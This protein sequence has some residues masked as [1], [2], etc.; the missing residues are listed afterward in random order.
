MNSNN[1]VHDKHENFCDVNNIDDDRMITDIHGSENAMDCDN[2][3][4]IE[5]NNHEKMIVDDSKKVTVFSRFLNENIS[6]LHRKFNQNYPELNI[7][8]SSFWKNI[9]KYFLKNGKKRTD[10]CHI[11][12]QGKQA[13]KI[14]KNSR[15]PREI[16]LVNF[17]I[18]KKI[19][20][21][22]FIY[23]SIYLYIKTFI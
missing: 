1:E 9:P 12:E 16:E 6:H 2:N 14:R 13:I 3:M 18:F 15:D 8:M 11:C 4:A 10:L 21:Q 20:H 17:K 7:S 23:Q 22:K 19:M 5:M